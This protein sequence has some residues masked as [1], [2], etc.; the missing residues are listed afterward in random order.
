MVNQPFNK[1]IPEI[2]QK[3]GGVRWAIARI[4]LDRQI[5]SESSLLCVDLHQTFSNDGVSVCPAEVL[6][7]ELG[8]KLGVVI[9]S[10]ALTEI[11][12]RCVDETAADIE[13]INR[14]GI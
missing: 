6:E 4:I 12:K 1:T 8:H 3:L 9:A 5:S 10:R 7:G 11:A 2:R 14:R 13:R